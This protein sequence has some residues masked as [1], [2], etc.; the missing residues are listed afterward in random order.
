[1]IPTHNGPYIYACAES[2]GRELT[3]DEIIGALDSLAYEAELEAAK[4]RTT[5]KNV[6]ASARP[7]PMENGQMYHAWEEARKVLDSENA[8]AMPPATENENGK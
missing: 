6:L 3:K 7:H 8:R 5:L 1:M 2:L 4:L